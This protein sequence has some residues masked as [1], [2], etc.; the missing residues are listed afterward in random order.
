MDNDIEL[1]KKAIMKLQAFHSALGEDSQIY[2]TE[3]EVG[4]F[5]LFEKSPE[6]SRDERLA[7]LMELRK[8]KREN[9][10]EFLRLKNMP[11]RARTGRKNH[12]LSGGT[13]AF[14][15]SPKRDAFSFV[16]KNGE[17]VELTFIEAAK[18]FKAAASE[19]SSP[20]HDKFHFSKSLS[21]NLAV[22]LGVDRGCCARG[23]GG[24]QNYA[25]Y[26]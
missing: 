24:V 1:R 5:G 15:K 16:S 20:L 13:L 11:L 25:E 21:S 26:G 19:K 3:E 14:I 17:L 12:L 6:E 22:T 23:G 10:Q 18:E 7:Y 9:P 8:F 2:S 4:T